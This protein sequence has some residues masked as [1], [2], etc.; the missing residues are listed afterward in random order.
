MTPEQ[1]A[2]KLCEALDQLDIS[3]RCQIKEVNDIIGTTIEI[4]N[5]HIRDRIAD[6]LRNIAS[7]AIM[8][9]EICDKTVT[10]R[11]ATALCRNC[12]DNII[13]TKIRR[14]KGLNNTPRS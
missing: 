14:C 1:I 10:K 2:R 5:G 9:C 7:D 6:V 3:D 4:F 13:P 11:S 8:E 12:E